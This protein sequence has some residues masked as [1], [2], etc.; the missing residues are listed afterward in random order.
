MRSVVV[1]ND[2][3]AWRAIA[4][5]LISSGVRPAD[6]HWID[7]SEQAVLWEAERDDDSS[8]PPKAIG[9]AFRVPKEFLRLAEHVACHRDTGRWAVLY[10]VLWRLTHGERNLLE[11]ATDEDVIAV[12]EMFK[13]VRR[14]VH[15]MKAFVRFRRVGEVHSDVTQEIYVAWHRPDHRIVRLAAP[16]FARR[17]GSMLWTIFTPDESARWDGESLQFGPGVPSSAA[18]KG[19]Q[20]ED[21]WR[22]YYSAT[23]NPARI[24]L[25]AMR[26][27]MPVRHWATLPET[28]IIDNMVREAPRRVEEMIKRQEGTARSAADFLPSRITLPALKKAS[29]TCEGCDLYKNATQT[30]FGQGPAEAEVMFV[31]E[32]PGDQEDLAGKPFVGPAG[33]I[34]DEAL[35]EASVDRETVYLTNAVKHFKW[36]PRGK[37]R[38]HGKPNSREISACRPWLEAEV[39][40][41]RP[42]MIVCLGATAAQALMGPSF[43]ITKQRGQVQN[44]EWSDWTM[45]TW[46][47]SAILRAPDEERRAAMREEFVADLRLVAKAITKFRKAK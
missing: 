17:F 40:V 27:E 42:R 44:T 8:L 26:R 43:R 39:E 22:A 38:L 31:G 9:G 16:F 23:F 34:L 29:K 21:L 24:K 35:V 10:N 19:D 1:E 47:P 7:A 2:F 20:L 41:V 46:H 45:A 18:P 4:R 3:A 12:N 11:V 13:A 25:K 14:D 6:I 33:R 32:Q 5:G 37:R 28:T 30:V 36:T 15:K